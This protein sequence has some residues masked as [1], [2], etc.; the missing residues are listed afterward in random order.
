M[1]VL[2]VM[3]ATF[4]ASLFLATRGPVVGGALT[5][6]CLGVGVWLLFIFVP[7]WG[8]AFPQQLAGLL[9]S[10]VGMVAGLWIH[11]R[12]DVAQFRRWTLVL[13]VLSGLN[14]VRRGLEILASDG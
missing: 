9:A 6:L 11:D 1:A 14:L 4:C 5:V 3:T 2:S 13:L 8:E 7:G 10:M 12:L